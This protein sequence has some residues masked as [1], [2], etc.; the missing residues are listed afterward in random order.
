MITRSCL[1]I[2]DC[3]SLGKISP[4]RAV[5]LIDKL[6]EKE[7]QQSRRLHKRFLSCVTIRVRPEGR[8]GLFFKVPI[9]LANFCLTLAGLSPKLRAKLREQGISLREIRS[10]VRFL[11][12]RE[13]G[14]D[15]RIEAKD[16]TKVQVYN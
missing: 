5:E 12:F 15:I 10:L 11:K 7:K 16:G 4:E 3:L 13:S 14:F 2:L 6:K 8:F 1:D 9:G